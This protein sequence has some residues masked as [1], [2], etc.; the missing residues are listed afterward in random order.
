MTAS[1]EF[2]V[3][4]L[5]D[6]HE[7]EC[8]VLEPALRS[9]GGRARFSG[10]IQTVRVFEDNVHVKATL[11]TPGEGRVLVVDGGGS[12]RCALMGDLLGDSAVA[13][14]WAGVVIHGCVRDI[15][16]LGGLP[17]GVLALSAMPRKSVKRGEGQVGET[18]SFLGACFT[19][20]AWLYADPDGVIV[21]SGPLI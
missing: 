11:A 19:P 4:D 18:V 1:P 12:R 21:A 7:T 6:A 3:C 15:E 20:G 8:Q 2:A 14:G 17:L 9:F 13:H 10:P 5:L 16:A